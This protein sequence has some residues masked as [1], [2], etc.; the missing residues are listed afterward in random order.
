VWLSAASHPV[1]S[2][3][4]CFELAVEVVQLDF[5]PSFLFSF[6]IAKSNV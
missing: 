4:F 2:A 1:S 6:C 5:L 3:W